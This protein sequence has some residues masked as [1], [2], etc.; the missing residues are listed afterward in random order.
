MERKI[1][2]TINETNEKVSV[3]FFTPMNT[4][5]G[6]FIFESQ[7]LYRHAPQSLLDISTVIDHEQDHNLTF[8]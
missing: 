4:S 8:H 1:I 3:F 5:Q 7:F 2:S 6:W